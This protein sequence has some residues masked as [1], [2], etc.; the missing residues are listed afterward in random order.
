[1]KIHP[2]SCCRCSASMRRLVAA[3]VITSVCGATSAAAIDGEGVPADKLPAFLKQLAATGPR[4]AA[5]HVQL[6]QWCQGEGLSDKAR[7]AFERAI[8]IDRDCEEARRALGH[9]RHGSGWGTPGSKTRAGAV[10]RQTDATAAA[11]TKSGADARPAA[12][13]S[14]AVEAAVDASDSTNAEVTKHERPT[15]EDPASFRDRAKERLAEKKKWAAAAAE[16]FATKFNTYENDDFLVHSPLARGD[17]SFKA[18]LKYLDHLKKTARTVLGVRSRGSIWPSKL[19]CVLL[20]SEPAYERFALNVDG[21]QSARTPDGAYTSGDHHVLWKPTSPLLARVVGSTALDGLYESDRPVGSWLKS[22]VA[23]LVLATSVIGKRD[24]HL[25]QR[26]SDAMDI[27]TEN[28]DGLALVFQLLEATGDRRQ[29]SDTEA[30]AMTLVDYLRR[31]STSG[32]GAFVKTLKSSDAPDPAA[33]GDDEGQYASQYIA[34]QEAE[35][36][37]NFRLTPSALGEKWRAHV[38]K[39]GKKAK[40]EVEAERERRRQAEEKANREKNERDRGNDRRGR[41]RRGR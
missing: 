30:L 24:L 27:L 34:F 20:R 5:D 41:G 35:L 7:E 2:R 10:K 23:E 36:Q 6:G 8:A 29:S 26:Y 12:V 40:A 13:E 16:R 1:M 37:K 39:V 32:F 11:P 31:K 17:K 9:V 18:L 25:Q 38:L 21:V 4:S 33:N 14:A 22:G 15:E 28:E 19:Q 3:V